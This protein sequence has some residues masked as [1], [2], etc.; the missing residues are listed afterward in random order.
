MQHQVG[1][2]HHR[3]THTGCHRQ[4]PDHI[5]LDKEQRQKAHRITDQ[6]QQTGN[7]ER[8]KRQSRRHQRALP[9]RRLMGHRID[10]L[11]AVTD[12]NGKYQERNQHRI[13]V[14]TKAQYPQN[15]QLP[16]HRD[17]RG[18]NRHQCRRDATRVC[19][20]QRPP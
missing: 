3:R 14:Q 13:G 10:D 6:R 20:K 15:P 7:I 2:D 12:G 4:I 5:D 17:N 8:T 9:Q 1:N 19:I 18:E 11:D 16:D